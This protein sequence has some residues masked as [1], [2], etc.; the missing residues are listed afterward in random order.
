[1][2]KGARRSVL[3]TNAVPWAEAKGLE[4]IL[5]VRRKPR[6]IEMTLRY[7]PICVLEVLLRVIG[8]DM[9]DRDGCLLM[10]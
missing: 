5:I 2:T 9:G 1:M 8:C 4:C 6:I 3:A 10:C 7:E